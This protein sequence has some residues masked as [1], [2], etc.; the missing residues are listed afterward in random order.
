MQ[1]PHGQLQPRHPHDAAAAA[2]LKQFRASIEAES[3][4]AHIIH[5][6]NTPLDKASYLQH[7]HKSD[8]S[9]SM[10]RNSDHKPPMEATLAL[11][12]VNHGVSSEPDHH[13]HEEGFVKQADW[14]VSGFEEAA[15]AGPASAALRLLGVEQQELDNASDNMHEEEDDEGIFDLDL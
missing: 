5:T 1:H 7:F 14:S 2:S 8:Q 3:C 9:T 15:V 4:V 6:R 12:S 13:Q 11:Q 10:P